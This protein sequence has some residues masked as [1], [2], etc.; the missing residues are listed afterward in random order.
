LIERALLGGAHHP[1]GTDIS[2][3]AIAI[4]KTNFTEANLT[5][6]T[7]DFICCDF[8]AYAARRLAPAASR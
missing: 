5:D 8:R 7:A 4:A 2:P 3:E 1:H 6:R